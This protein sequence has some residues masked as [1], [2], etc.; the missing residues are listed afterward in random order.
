[1][2]I[3]IHTFCDSSAAQGI[4][5]RLG[6]GKLRNLEVKHLWLQE[7]AKK[8]TLQV[9][10]IPR[11]QNPADLLTHAVS[12]QDFQN[13]LALLPVRVTTETHPACNVSATLARDVFM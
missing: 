11:K 9:F 5:Q 7:L 4:M 1:M 12:L 13:H 3:P 6:T 8:K 2:K 10:W